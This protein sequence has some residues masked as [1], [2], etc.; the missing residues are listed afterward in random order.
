VADVNG[1]RRP[2]LAAGNVG[3]DET[4]AVLINRSP[5][6]DLGFALAGSAGAPRLLGRGTLAGGTDVLVALSRAR[7]NAPAILLLSRTANPTPFLG[8]VVL[9]I[10][11]LTSL[12]ALTSASGSV[13]LRFTPW[14]QGLPP[15]GTLV[16]QYA[17]LDPGAVLGLA[18]SNGLRCTLP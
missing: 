9:P 8:G 18:L 1:D 14:P 13:D 6:A 11:V 4:A 10:P 3:I 7:P 12:P 15:N 5:W 2:D 17:I 16:W